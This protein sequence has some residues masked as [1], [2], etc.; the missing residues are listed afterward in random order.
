MGIRGG[1]GWSATYSKQYGK[2]RWQTLL[3]AL[4]DA[5][6][7]VAFVSPRISHS[8]LRYLLR[9][10]QLRPCLIP[11]CFIPRDIL[12]SDAGNTKLLSCAPRDPSNY[13]AQA[14]HA[15]AKSEA[16]QPDEDAHIS[17]SMKACTNSELP[18]SRNPQ[19]IDD[20]H[21]VQEAR[22]MTYF[23]GRLSSCRHA[24]SHLTNLTSAELQFSTDHLN[25][26]SK[27]FTKYGCSR[28]LLSADGAS[29]LAA[30]ALGARPGE[31]VLDMCAAP[32][33]KSLIISS[34]LSSAKT[35]SYL[36]AN[37]STLYQDSSVDDELDE[38][39]L[40][41]CND[42]SRQRLM[43]LQTSLTKFLP[44]YATTGQHLQFSCSDG[45]KGG[46]FER[47][48]PYDKILLD[49]PCS[50]D[51]HLLH[52]GR[53]ALANWSP[54]TP[55]A[56]AERQLKMLLT[57]SKLLKKNGII[58]Y[59]TCSLSHMENEAVIEKF[60]TKTKVS[61]KVLPL[62]DGEWPSE[63]KLLE[64]GD[65]APDTKLSHSYLFIIEKLVHGYTMLPDI[66]NFG[67]MYFCRMQ[68]VGN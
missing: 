20:D 24:C 33:G 60:L 27:F 14:S 41:V 45:C 35:P 37:Q 3:N 39:G 49:A 61:I 38:G 5:P 64:K 28:T 15:S 63:V 17:L 26:V 2:E 16:L 65:S 52:E 8:A 40:L 43:R 58:L 53:S 51:R 29:A 66:S 1:G 56:C 50:S 42:A 36:L 57:A 34:M 21:V 55:K 62:F 31:V 13:G 11:N 7:Q 59:T 46:A 44:E 10:P 48:A 19:I 68:V 12:Q 54:G 6:N 23:L 47:F 9:K 67:P 22:V 4:A 32:G 18:L 30:Y 25:S